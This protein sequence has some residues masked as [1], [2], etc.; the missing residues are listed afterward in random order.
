MQTAARR[1]LVGLIAALVWAVPV[2]HAHVTDT[3]ALRARLDYVS[4]VLV[5][6]N[7]RHGTVAAYLSPLFLDA[8]GRDRFL[9]NMVARIQSRGLTDT[10]VWRI[11]WHEPQID[12]AYGYASVRAELCG[13]GKLWL[14][15]CVDLELNWRWVEEAWYLLPPERIVLDPEL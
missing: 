9:L 6:K 11:R 13:L 12:A 2:A 14:P 15:R 7:A 10:R 1:Y 5:G 8:D 4:Q 3:R